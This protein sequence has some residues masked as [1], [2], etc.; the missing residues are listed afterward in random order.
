[1]KIDENN[2]SADFFFQFFFSS[3]AIPYVKT[4]IFI[5]T[6]APN[7]FF[8]AFYGHFKGILCAFY[9]QFMTIL[10]HLRSLFGPEM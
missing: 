10:A 2:F 4:M 5:S 9:G 1:M 3:Q 8:W 6:F 7:D